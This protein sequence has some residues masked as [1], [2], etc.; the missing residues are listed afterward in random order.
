M[1]NGD[2]T[3]LDDNPPPSPPTPRASASTTTHRRRRQRR[4][5]LRRRQR[6][7]RLRRRQ[8]RHDE[9]ARPSTASAAVVS[10]PSGRTS[11][12]PSSPPTPDAAN[13]T[14]ANVAAV[15]Q[16]TTR[17][18][19]ADNQP[20]TRQQPANTIGANTPPTFRQR[21]AS[22]RQRQPAASIYVDDNP[23]SST[24]TEVSQSSVTQSL[25]LDQSQLRV[26]RL[27]VDLV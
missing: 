8:R 7:V 20:T 12:R 16:P 25:K 5:R 22:L 3:K 14:G 10:P 27:S 21:R 24:S 23:P 26:V 4:I 9:G 18:Q 13:V 1:V 2:L 17:R 6:R 11:A 15:N 19:P